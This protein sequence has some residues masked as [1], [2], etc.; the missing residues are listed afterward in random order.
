MFYKIFKLKQKVKTNFDIFLFMI[1]KCPLSFN[2]YTL[3]GAVFLMLQLSLCFKSLARPLYKLA[4]PTPR[5]GEEGDSSNTG[6]S[7]CYISV[8]LFPNPC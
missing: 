5:V 2:L 3:K 1:L 4:S 7:L 8:Q 6:P